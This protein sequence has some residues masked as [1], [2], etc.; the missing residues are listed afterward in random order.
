MRR[1]EGG[2][3][4]A[5]DWYSITGPGRCDGKADTPYPNNGLMNQHCAFN[6]VR[7]M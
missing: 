5:L 7:W 3:P 4:S 6:E 2:T 1:R